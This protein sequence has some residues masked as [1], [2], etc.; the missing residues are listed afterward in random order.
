MTQP[1]LTD[2]MES[3]DSKTKVWKVRFACAKGAYDIGK[4]GECESLLHRLMEQADGLEESV[5]ATNT[6][7]I[8][9]GAVYIATGKIDKAKHHL[10]IAINS[11]SGASSTSLR[12]LSALAHRFYAEALRE[13]GDEVG[14]ENE[15]EQAVHILTELGVSCAVP[16]AYALSELAALYVTQEKLRDAKRLILS[17]MELLRQSVGSEDQ[18]YMRASVISNICDSEGEEDMLQ[19][20][21]DGIS[22]LQYQFGG[23]HP[24]ITRAIRGYQKKCQECGGTDTLDDE[25]EDG[26]VHVSGGL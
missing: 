26:F 5:F 9:L 16:L 22:K 14:A 17:A 24:S 21:D 23:K 20:I 13:A 10:E 12:E 6:C 4:F 2:A 7:H 3:H 11:L 15:L 8:G 18:E 19:R 1:R 25:I